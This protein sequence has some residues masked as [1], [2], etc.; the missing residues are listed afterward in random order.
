MYCAIV[1]ECKVTAGGGGIAFSQAWPSETVVEFSNPL[2]YR[3]SRS[4]QEDA[5]CARPPLIRN[6]QRKCVKHAFLLAGLK[7]LA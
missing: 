5:S 2:V 4:S 3:S 1:H 7:K 6:L